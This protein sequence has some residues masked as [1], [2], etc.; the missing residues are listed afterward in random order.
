MEWQELLDLSDWG[1][2]RFE[3]RKGWDDMHDAGSIH[4][5]VF[6]DARAWGGL[7][8][9]C[10]RGRDAGGVAAARFTMMSMHGRKEDEQV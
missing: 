2:N 10:R 3:E 8:M 4:L 1:C 7:I 9:S 6:D 5:A